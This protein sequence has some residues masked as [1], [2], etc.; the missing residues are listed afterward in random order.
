MNTAD[1]SS[2]IA[3][4]IKANEKYIDNASHLQKDLSGI[5]LRDDYILLKDLLQRYIHEAE[6]LQTGFQE[7]L[8]KAIELEASWV[9]QELYSERWWQQKRRTLFEAFLQDPKKGLSHWLQTYAEALLAWELA[10]CKKL[11]SESFPF[12]TQ[13]VDVLALFRDGTKAIED[14]TYLQALDMLVYLTQST[15]RTQSQPTL[16]EISQAI[17]LV[18]MGRINLYKAS[19]REVALNLFE[20]AKELA[21]KDGLPYT[22]LG[23]Y[24]RAQ[25]DSDR[26]CPGRKRY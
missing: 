11:V 18:F 24:Y 9:R 16:D 26:G 4:I 10:I 13:A 15:L 12:P 7:T 14:E 25:Q 8:A 21:P 5:A 1:I 17:L 22:A 23:S 2:V 6:K 20:R 19:Y 3:L